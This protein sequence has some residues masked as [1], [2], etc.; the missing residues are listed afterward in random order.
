[1]GD[2]TGIADVSYEAAAEIVAICDTL[3]EERDVKIVE[4]LGQ[5]QY[6]LSDDS[7]LTTI[8]GAPGFRIEQV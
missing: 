5:A 7:Q 1:M 3:V 6:Q 4:R 8:I 2:D